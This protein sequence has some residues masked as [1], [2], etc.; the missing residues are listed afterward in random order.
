MNLKVY[1]TVITLS[2]YF[3]LGGRSIPMGAAAEPVRAP[4]RPTVLDP[5]AGPDGA[6]PVEPLVPAPAPRRERRASW[7][8]F[9]I[10]ALL[11]LTR[12]RTLSVDLTGPISLLVRTAASSR[13]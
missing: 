1:Y 4:V 10:K 8:D 9:F 5:D 13:P 6:A 7:R 11:A 2:S 12:W 3:L